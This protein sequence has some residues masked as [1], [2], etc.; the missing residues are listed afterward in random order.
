MTEPLFTQLEL[1]GIN[2]L[3]AGSFDASTVFDANTPASHVAYSLGVLGMYLG[4]GDNFRP[5][6]IQV[7]GAQ[8]PAQGGQTPQGQG[9]CPPGTELV[10]VLGFT[11]CGKVL[12]SDDSNLGMVTTP[13]GLLTGLIGEDT[14]KRIALF[15]IAIVILA[16]ALWKM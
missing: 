12:H 4:P 14:I 6:A 10:S 16:V 5:N 9:G 15:L 7:G 8:A 3:T 2:A 11:Y 1:P 13:T